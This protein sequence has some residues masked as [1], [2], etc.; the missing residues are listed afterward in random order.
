MTVGCSRGFSCRFQH[1]NPESHDELQLYYRM[2]TDPEAVIR[3]LGIKTNKLVV[4]DNEDQPSN[5]TKIV[6]KREVPLEEGDVATRLEGGQ[7]SVVLS[8]PIQQQN[9]NMMG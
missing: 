8:A 2:Q 1:C 9:V 4:H 6:Y 5:G 3:E 7:T